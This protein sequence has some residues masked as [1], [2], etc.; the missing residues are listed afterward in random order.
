M[1]DTAL[2]LYLQ[3]ADNH[4]WANGRT[5]WYNPETWTEKLG[6]IGKYGATAMIS[7]AN[8]FYNTGVAVGNF[9][10]ADVQTNDTSAF[11][12]SLDSDLGKYYGEN[13]AA[14]DLGGFV[15]GSL[16]PGLG[17]IRIFNAGQKALVAATETGFIGGNLGRATGLLT[18][19]VQKYVALATKDMNA[20]ATSLQILNA[21]T[22]KA[23]AAGLWQNT[24]EAAAFETAVQVTMFKS[25][26]LE[27]QD[28]GD[29][30][31]NVATGG[32]IGGAVGGIFTGIKTWGGLK[33]ASK[34]EDVANIK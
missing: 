32:L 21:N 17:G 3:A 4:N 9:F 22:S 13:Q 29:I 24:L 6:N 11:I 8:S 33:Q 30:V 23:L 27:Q 34:A 12:S 16:I 25:P 19:N 31:A 10:G 2:P 20:S 14:V 7:G 15:L 1:A 18:P 5:S 26:V 28:V